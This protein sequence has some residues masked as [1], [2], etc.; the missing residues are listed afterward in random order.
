LILIREKK[1]EFTSSLSELTA[2]RH[3]LTDFIGN[4]FDE[5]DCNRVILSIDEAVANIII[6]GYKGRA[7]GKIE[8]AMLDYNDRIRVVLLDDAPVFNPLTVSS[9]D[10]DEYHAEGKNSGLGVDLYKRLMHASY[11]K[12]ENGGNCLI[13]EKMKD[14]GG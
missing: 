6:H 2:L 9:P 12:K 3:A 5:V 1:I 8:V 11:E 13:L 4:N 7:D 14:Y 10:I